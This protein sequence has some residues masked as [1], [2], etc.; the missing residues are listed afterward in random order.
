MQLHQT[1]SLI[2]T[3]WLASL[4]FGFPS[5]FGADCVCAGVANCCVSGAKPYVGCCWSSIR[6]CK[7]IILWKKYFYVFI[8]FNM[9]EVQK[10]TKIFN[11]D[12]CALGI[13]REERFAAKLMFSFC[14]FNNDAMIW[15]ITVIS[16]T[17]L[18]S[19]KIVSQL[20]DIIFLETKKLHTCCC[21]K[22]IA[23]LVIALG[24]AREICK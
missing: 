5:V 14:W 24:W 19:E 4:T 8:P 21:C 16:L 22:A 11:I 15:S 10:P 12:G 17:R 13:P 9:R 3:C 6:C 7:P 1:Y 2:P 20:P 23:T 18:V